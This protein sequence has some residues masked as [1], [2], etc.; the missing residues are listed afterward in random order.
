MDFHPIFVHF[1][2]ALLTVYSLFEL[3]RFKKVLDNPI[4]F[5]MKALLLILGT[6]AALVAL[7]TGDLAKQ[8]HAVRS[9][10]VQTHEFFAQVTAI[11]FSVLASGYIWKV[12]SSSGL[13]FG[14]LGKLLNRISHFLIE[15]W[16][17]P[18]IA[19]AGLVAL[20]ITGALGAYMV[21]GAGIDPFVNFIAK[22]LIK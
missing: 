15:T 3:I 18:L 6:A 2:I 4:V 9:Q 22:L 16:F 1:P 14:S 5:G 10:A 20:T 8:M 19:L 7:E 13:N 12:L 11:L 21:Y 17:A